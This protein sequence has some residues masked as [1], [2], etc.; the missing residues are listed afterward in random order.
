MVEDSQ[1]YIVSQH[2]RITELPI[3]NNGLPL[4]N[5]KTSYL[6]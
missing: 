4:L 5:P 6:N 1:F 2:H 3:W